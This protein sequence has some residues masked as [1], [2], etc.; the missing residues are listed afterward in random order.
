VRRKGGRPPTQLD[1]PY[2][3]ESC[4]SASPPAAPGAAGVSKPGCSSGHRPLPYRVRDRRSA[5]DGDRDRP[6]LGEHGLDR[7]LS[8]A[9]VRLRLRAHTR[10]DPPSRSSSETGGPLDRGFRHCLDHD[11]GDRGQRL[12]PDRSG[13]D[14]RRA[15]RQLV[16]VEPRSEPRDRVRTDGAR[17]PMADRTGTRARGYARTPRP[18]T[19]PPRTTAP[20]RSVPLRPKDPRVPVRS[21]RPRRPCDCARPRS[22][23]RRATGPVAA[24][25]PE[26]AVEAADEPS[27]LVARLL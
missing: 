13:R 24:R 2:S 4:G 17:E 7:D 27:L 20:A 5:R 12:H 14:R 25:S 11:D 15:D 16:L 18:L 23:T 3:S 8:R 10:P 26:P 19:T 9:R 1:G 22:A 6:R 21:G